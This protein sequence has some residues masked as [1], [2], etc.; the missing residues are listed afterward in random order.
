M[1]PD[2]QQGFFSHFL[3]DKEQTLVFVSRIHFK[4]ADVQI[5]FTELRFGFF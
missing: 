1:L 4:V 2:N 3:L 5:E